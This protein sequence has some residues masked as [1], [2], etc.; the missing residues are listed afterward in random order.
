MSPF[1]GFKTVVLVEGELSDYFSMKAGVHQRSALG[2][3]LFAIVIYALTE[4]MRLDH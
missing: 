3:L 1:Q 4:D 2:P